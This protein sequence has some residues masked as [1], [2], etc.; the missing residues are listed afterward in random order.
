MEDLRNGP[1]LRNVSFNTIPVE[2]ELTPYE[3]LMED[4]RSKKYQ[5]NKV[6][7]IFLL[8]FFNVRIIISTKTAQIIICFCSNYRSIW[9]IILRRLFRRMPTMWFYILLGLDLH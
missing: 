9:V 8:F 5:L 3:L 7:I 2:Y 1:K 6:T 4:I